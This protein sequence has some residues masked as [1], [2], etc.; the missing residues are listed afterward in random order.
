MVANLLIDL[1]S[2]FLEAHGIQHNEYIHEN[3]HIENKF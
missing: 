2:A 3:T 1:D